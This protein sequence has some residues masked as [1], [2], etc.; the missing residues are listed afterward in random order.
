[1]E[2]LTTFLLSLCFLGISALSIYLG[3][4]KGGKYI[5]ISFI[6]CIICL[7]ISLILA[8]KSDKLLKSNDSIFNNNTT[9]VR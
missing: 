7:V 9:N 6:A 4:K 2:F 1:M 5:A 8:F 3:I